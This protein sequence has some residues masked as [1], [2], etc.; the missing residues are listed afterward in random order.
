M[1]ADIEDGELIEDPL[2]KILEA[3]GSIS[4]GVLCDTILCWIDA[5]RQCGSPKKE[6]ENLVVSN[7]EP[8]EIHEAKE[9]L[10]DFIST[11]RSELLTD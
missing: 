6:V 5:R 2:V 8:T 1:T 3:L 10:K 7:F 11:K 4:A 9:T